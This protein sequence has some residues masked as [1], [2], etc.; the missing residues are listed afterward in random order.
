MPLRTCLACDKVSEKESLLRF[1]V[2]PN[3]GLVGDVTRRRDG[4]GYYIHKDI[5]CLCSSYGWERIVGKANSIL[6]KAG[7]SGNVSSLNLKGIMTIL[8]GFTAVG[9]EELCRVIKCTAEELKSMGDSKFLHGGKALKRRT[10]DLMLRVNRV[11][12][13]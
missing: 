1:V 8:E 10:K 11:K 7:L 9:D 2:D 12:L 4:R 13:K 3:D 5:K 6:K